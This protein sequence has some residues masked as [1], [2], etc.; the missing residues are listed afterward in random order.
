[1]ARGVSFSRRLPEGFGPGRIVVSPGA[2][3]GVAKW[4]LASADPLLF[5]TVCRLVRPAKNIWDIGA[6]LG[7][8]GFASAWLAGSQARLLLVEAD[9]WLCSLLQRSRR[10]LAGKGYAEATVACCAISDQV[11]PISFD[12]AARG[13]ASNAISGLGNSQMGGRRGSL[14]VGAATLDQLLRATFPPDLVKID[15]EGAEV[16]VL[17][18][19]A[20]V[21]AHRPVLVIEVTDRGAEEATAILLAAGYRLH[22]AGQN[23]LPVE[24]CAWA[25][26][27]CPA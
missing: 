25:T 19:A 24:R 1:M 21:L 7:L 17:R 9:P 2:S 18:E 23:M 14:L 4:N 5:A 27:A 15:V 12:I 16:A 6:N 20:T 11:G 8:F 10:A 13:R 26:V 22:D 3:L